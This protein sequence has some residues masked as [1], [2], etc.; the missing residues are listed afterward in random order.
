MLVHWS[1]FLEHVQPC[2]CA[3]LQ[4]IFCCMGFGKSHTQLL[5]PQQNNFSDL[6]YWNIWKTLCGWVLTYLHTTFTGLLWIFT[7][8]ITFLNI[9]YHLVV[10][11]TFFVLNLLLFF[12]INCCPANI[13]LLK[14]IK[15]NTRTGCVIYSKVKDKV[16]QT[17]ALT[18]N[19]T[20]ML[21]YWHYINDIVLVYL[22]SISNIFLQL[23]VNIMI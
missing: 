17:T 10:W 2:N 5:F 19:Q 16:I 13:N 15:R 18:K 11:T 6:K 14:I 12:V 22:F 9:K 1:Q 7:K 8:E 3:N 21:V 4:W 20:M 23:G